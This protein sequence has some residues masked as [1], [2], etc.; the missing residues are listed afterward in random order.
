MTSEVFFFGG[1]ALALVVGIGVLIH[2]IRKQDGLSIAA[3]GSWSLAAGI[4]LLLAAA[5]HYG[6]R[7]SWVVAKLWGF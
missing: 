1:A 6:Y 7:L 4:Y 3:S 5:S 2:A